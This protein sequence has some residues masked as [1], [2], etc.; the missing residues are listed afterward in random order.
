MTPLI[1]SNGNILELLY[2]RLNKYVYGMTKIK[3]E[4][5]AIVANVFMGAK[6]KHKIFGM[7]GPPGVGKTMIARALAEILELPLEQFSMGGAY[8]ASFLEGHGFTYEGSEPGIIVKSLINMKYTNGIFFIDEAEKTSSRHSREL[9]HAL[10]HIIDFTQNHDFRDK[11]MPEIPIDL[12][13]NTF[14]LSMNSTAGMDAAL[15]SRIPIITFD[16]YTAEE[17]QHILQDFILPE[18]LENYGFKKGDLTLNKATTKYLINKT[19]EEGGSR[20]KSGVRALKFAVNRIVKN[21][22][23]FMKCDGKVK[24]S[25]EIRDFKLP[26]EIDIKTVDKI[27]EK[28]SGSG[29]VY[30]RSM[31]Y[32]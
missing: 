9:E 25:F 3:E 13:N 15:I 14:I 10:L 31:M 7:V 6:S 18:I 1:V 19:P 22:N 27:I 17:K 24:L 5:L 8:D 20:D 21:I 29:D 28:P 23:L 26:F 4:I 11:Y 32:S 12:S 30:Y 2:N 16:G